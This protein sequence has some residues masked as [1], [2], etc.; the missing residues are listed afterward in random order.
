MIDE[1]IIDIRQI[2]RLIRF[3]E[4]ISKLIHY[5]H[6]ATTLQ[7]SMINVLLIKLC[8]DCLNKF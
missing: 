7:H 1:W 6:F 4:K 3:S 8:V 2:R 5:V